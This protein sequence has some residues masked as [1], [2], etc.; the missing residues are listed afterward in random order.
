MLTGAQAAEERAR[1]RYIV[2]CDGEASTTRAALHL[3]L[4]G[5]AYPKTTSSVTSVR[6]PHP[7]RPPACTSS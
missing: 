1:F 3:T 6:R 2:G 4:R 5:E 7:P